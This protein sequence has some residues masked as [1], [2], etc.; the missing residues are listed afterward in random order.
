MKILLAVL[1]LI[2]AFAVV[3]IDTRSLRSVSQPAIDHAASVARFAAVAQAERD[4]TMDDARSVLFDH[5]A[6]T[7][8]VVVLVHGF[9]NSPRQFR[10]LGQLL[11]DR[12]YNVLIPRLPDHGLRS[13]DV[14]ALKTLTAERYRDYADRAVDDARGLGD[15]VMVVGLSAGADV[16]IWIAQHRPDVTRV[17]VIA[18]AISLARVPA[19]FDAPVMNLM[20]RVPNMT[21]HQKPDT[22]RPHAYFGVSTRAVAQ[23]LRFGASVMSDVEHGGP[24]VHDLALVVNGNDHTVDAAPVVRI[25]EL[26]RERVGTR[27]AFYR[28]ATELR[29]PHDLIDATQ[30]CGMPDVVYPVVVALLEAREPD[31]TGDLTPRCAPTK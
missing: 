30:R 7:S 31:A 15:S 13:G 2:T 6:R 20:T 22:L 9:T 1:G 14:G 12:G 29:L 23:T 26:W 25:A 8:R 10:E 19:L 16:A 11:F 27:T 4:S 18:P 5:G 28:F 24:A 21:F 17:V 3:P